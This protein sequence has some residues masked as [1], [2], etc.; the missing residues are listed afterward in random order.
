LPTF[1]CHRGLWCLHFGKALLDQQPFLVS[2][3]KDKQHI[4]RPIS[5]KGLHDTNQKVPVGTLCGACDIL[6]RLPEY[7]SVSRGFL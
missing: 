5:A 6:G 7:F 4:V 2:L 3:Q 1:V